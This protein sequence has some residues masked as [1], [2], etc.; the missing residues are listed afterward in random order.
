MCG[1][2]IKKDGQ[3]MNKIAIVD[4]RDNI[5]GYSSKYNIHKKGILHAAFSI[6]LYHDNKILLQCR[7]KKKYHSGG[8]IANTCCSH[9]TV[10]CDLITSA[11]KRLKDEV[12]IEVDNLFDIGSFVYFHKFH[13]N[14]YEYELD[15]VLIAEST[16]EP[17]INKNEVKWAKWIDIKDVITD[18]TNNPEK[19]C[20]WFF[21]AFKLFLDYIKYSV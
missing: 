14:L 19:Y 11:K 7:A 4:L 12:G 20:V 16:Y 9:R 15:H 17:N 13:E 8:L 21:N 3:M 2:L 18:I 1:F 6:F 5:I 10:D